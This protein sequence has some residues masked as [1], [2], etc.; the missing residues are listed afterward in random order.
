MDYRDL[1]NFGVLHT[2]KP[3]ARVQMSAMGWLTKELGVLKSPGFFTK[4]LGEGRRWEAH[5]FRAAEERKITDRE[6][7]EGVRS[8]IAAH[9]SLLEVYG[10]ERGAEVYRRFAEKQGVMLWEDFIPTAQDFL[11]CDDPWEALRQYF[12]EYFRVNEREGIFRYEV[13]QDDDSELHIRLVDCAWFAMYGEAGCAE[14][15]GVSAQAD[16]IF[17]SRLLRKMGGDFKRPC[18]ICRG[19]ST[20]DWRFLRHRQ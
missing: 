1:K 15:P 6:F 17:L 18:W 13:V 19:D 7:F 12:L 10:A 3:S 16:V 9:R 20:C 14:L 5:E 4:M 8:A 2:C 11:D